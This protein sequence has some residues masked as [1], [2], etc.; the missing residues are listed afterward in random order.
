ML[1]ELLDKGLQL[2][3]VTKARKNIKSRLLAWPDKLALMER[4]TFEAVND[5]LRSVCAIDH[6]HHG[7]HIKALAQDFLE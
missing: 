3:Q 5:I 6:T 4:G 2:L 7:N 1:E